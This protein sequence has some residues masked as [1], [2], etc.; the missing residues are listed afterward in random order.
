MEENVDM[1]VDSGEKPRPEIVI[2]LD[3]M[4]DMLVGNIFK[5][6]LLKV[7]SIVCFKMILPLTS[8][9]SRVVVETGPAD[10]LGT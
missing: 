3:V 1:N 4:Q 10:H 8:F 5:M 2:K 7:K 6:L 9:S